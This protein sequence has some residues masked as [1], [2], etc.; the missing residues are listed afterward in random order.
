MVICQR[1]HMHLTQAHAGPGR[2]T[3]A[4]QHPM[5]RC[6]H[7]ST[8]AQPQHAGST[9]G[10]ATPAAV[11]AVACGCSLGIET[12]P[13]ASA[14]RVSAV[15]ASVAGA[16]AA[17]SASAPR[18]A[19]RVSASRSAPGASPPGASPPGASPVLAGTCS[20]CAASMTAPDELATSVAAA[21]VATA[22]GSRQAEHS[23]AAGARAW[24]EG[25]G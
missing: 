10:S 12:G 17:L 21:S 14:A 19:Q 5:L 16:R 3:H 11:V 24:F 23:P 4:H 1:A 25:Q 13:V 7:A 22:P 9:R 15:G 20:A 18:A 2:Q 6:P 8:C